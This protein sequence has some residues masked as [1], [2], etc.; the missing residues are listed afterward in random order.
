MAVIGYI[1]RHS[2]IAVILVG[3]SLVAFLVGPNLIDWAKNVLGYSSGP[4]SKREVGIING[5]SISLIEFESSTLRNVEL[6]KLNQQKPDLTAEEIFNIKD[7]TWTQRL[8]EVIMQEEYDKLGL[9]ISPDEMIDLL[10]GNNP[11]R[12][13]RQYFVNENGL[14][15][16]NLVVQ[17]MQNIDRLTPGDRAQWESFK[18]FIYNDRLNSKYRALISKGFYFPKAFAEI[19]YKNNSDII[20]FRYAGLKYADIADSLVAESTDDQYKEFYEEIKHQANEVKSRD[21]EFVIFNI[22]PSEEDLLS[23]KEEATEIF[24]E[25][26]TSSNPTEYV[27]NIPG[28]HYDSS[29]YARGELSVYIDSLM[30]TEEIG[31][32]TDGPYKDG[33]AWYMARLVDRQVRPDSASAEHV[34]ISYEGAF[35]VDPNNTRTKENATLLADSI[36]RVLRRDVSKLPE[37]ATAMSDD[38]S[39]VNNNGNIGWFK[40]GEMVY[41]FNK[42]AINGKEG[43]VVMVETPFGYH[44]IHITGL[45]EAEE[46]VRVAQIEVPIEYSSETFDRYYA[47][48]SR[49]A[50]ENNTLEKFNQAVIDEGLEKR[51]SKYIQEMQLGLP[52]L[53]N[54][55][56]VIR[57]VFWDDKEVGDVSP[58]FDI[59]GK[60]LVVAYTAGRET[61]TIPY[62]TMKDRL[63]VNMVNDRKAEYLT[64][65]ISELGT[66]DI[67]VIAQTFNTK[68]DTINSITF[69]SRNIPGYGTEHDVLGKLF[70]CNE[71]ENSGVI[72]GN[73]ALFIAQLDKVYVAPELDNYTSYIN[74]K[75]VNFESFLNNNLHY[76][77]LEHNAVVE[78][79]RRYF[80]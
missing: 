34:L 17:Y 18:E 7:Q 35:R 13:I 2:A 30:F 6:T 53:E 45:T 23:I 27:N 19:E 80:Y 25:W 15:D 5:Q 32:Y 78:D 72:E 70:A 29:W 54:T 9:T 14:Y 43:E 49:F 38:A 58:L 12:L 68:V 73:G 1:R 57:W 63:E 39:V 36:Y 61:G 28:N 76:K 67:Y 50:G 65:K 31:T 10:R 59:G 40:D 64:E 52:S 46:R 21:I 56:Q 75:S 33:P 55:R 3:I 37:I 20:G 42:A 69:A 22:L 8:T 26:V 66:D 16:P 71:G 79:F 11:H 74:Q 77:A 4:G 51:E 44:I 47:M 60:F 24:D 62:E 48:A 41:A